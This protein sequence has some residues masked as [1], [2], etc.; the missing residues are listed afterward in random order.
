MPNTWQSVCSGID[1]VREELLTP[2]LVALLRRHPLKAGVSARFSTLREVYAYYLQACRTMQVG[3]LKRQADLVYWYDRLAPLQMFLPLAERE[4]AC[5]YID[6]VLKQ[7]YE[8]DWE[9]GTEYFSTLEQYLRCFLNTKMAARALCIHVNT[10]LYRIKH[11]T[12]LFYIDFSDVTF[13]NTLL[14]SFHL[15]RASGM[16]A[17][18]LCR[19]EMN[20]PPTQAAVK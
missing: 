14:C 12:E 6:P 7:I 3:R 9:N 10:L 1:T 20:G 4:S 8:Y 17:E 16:G 18:E 15:L 2:P 19:E 11:M 13:M 5:A